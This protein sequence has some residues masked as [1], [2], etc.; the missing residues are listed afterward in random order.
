MFVETRA[1]QHAF[2]L[3]QGLGWSKGRGKG[4]LPNH[5]VEGAGLGKN[6]RALEQ[7]AEGIHTGLCGNAS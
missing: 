2:H 4:A 5:A 1:G 3:A 6:L 7:G